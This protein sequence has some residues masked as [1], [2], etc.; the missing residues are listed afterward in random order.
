MP[1]V[2]APR[3]T[4]RVPVE[5]GAIRLETVESLSPDKIRD[6]PVYHGNRQTPF[7]QLFDVSGSAGEDQTIVFRGDCSRVKRI[8]EGLTRGMVCVEGDAGMHSGA[9]MRGGCLTITGSAGDWLGAEMQGGRIVV[10]GDA[11]DLVGAA[12]RGARRGMRGGEILVHGNAGREIGHSMRRGLIA[13]GG[14]AGDAA[15]FNM[16]AGTLIVCGRTGAR[17][18][19]GMR[20]GTVCLL[21]TSSRHRLLPT[22][23]Y[24]CRYQPHFLNLYLQFLRGRGFPVPATNATTMFDRFSGDLVELG[25]GEVLLRVADGQEGANS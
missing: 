3:S 21:E 8:A 9:R 20:R 12:M 18:A 19:A 25:K 23:R 15:G 13:I 24:A 5:V 16:I 7:G 6:I 22:F 14:A 17:P 1:L 4:F 10:Q 2:F 11:G